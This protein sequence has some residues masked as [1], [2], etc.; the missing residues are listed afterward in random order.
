MLDK[1]FLEGELVE[2]LVLA[3][4]AFQGIGFVTAVSCPFGI[5][6]AGPGTLILAWKWSLIA[7]VAGVFYEMIL[8][9]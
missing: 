2:E 1:V 3:K 5:L 8:E 9:L 6:L 4:G 7:M